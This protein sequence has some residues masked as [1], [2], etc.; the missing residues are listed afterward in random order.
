MIEVP[1]RYVHTLAVTV[2]AVER[3]FPILLRAT[4][5]AVEVETVERV[6][7][8]RQDF[9]AWCL[10]WLDGR[11]TGEGV[12]TKCPRRWRRRGGWGRGGAFIETN[13]A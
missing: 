13:E 4:A 5:A 7:C 9:L 12:C 10:R 3:G 11:L 6:R 2:F 1:A 8:C